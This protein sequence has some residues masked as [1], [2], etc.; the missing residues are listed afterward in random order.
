M[1]LYVN[2]PLPGKHYQNPFPKKK[3]KMV[4]HFL[5]YTT[6]I[7]QKKKMYFACNTHSKNEAV[8]YTCIPEVK[9]FPN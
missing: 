7:L 8:L 4:F 2:V 9:T 1:F 3:N 5:S 6:L